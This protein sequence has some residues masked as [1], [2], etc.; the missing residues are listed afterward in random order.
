MASQLE[1]SIRKAKYFAVS[2]RMACRTIGSNLYF[3]VGREEVILYEDGRVSCTCK[4][5]TINA[6]FG[7][8]C[9]HIFAAIWKS[10]ELCKDI[11][12]I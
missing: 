6:K 9:A 8:Y 10:I 5:Q 4:N 3:K 12:K 1:Y 11:R 7:S 2:N